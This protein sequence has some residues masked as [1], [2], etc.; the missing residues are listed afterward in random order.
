MN[1]LAHFLW[2]IAAI[3]LNLVGVIV[4][5]LIAINTIKGLWDLLMS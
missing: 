2:A 1:K 4:I 3:L 5:A